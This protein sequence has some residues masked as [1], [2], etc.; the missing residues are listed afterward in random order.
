[1]KPEIDVSL[2]ILADHGRAATFLIHDGIL[3]ANDGRGYVLRKILRRAIRHGRILG[4]ERAFLYQ[5]VG[6]VAELMSDAYPE[7]LETSERVA[8]VVKSEEQRFA[9]TI[10][11]AMHEFDKVA[12]ESGEAGGKGAVILRGD[13][14]FRLY[15]TF[16][17]P[18]DWIKEIAGERGL[19]VD[20]S[21]F[22]TE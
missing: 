4:L 16:G 20:E 22:E 9:Q 17:M 13:K 11:I 21:G 12:K 7:L 3:P 5:M 2:R 15:D 10:T 8:A 1:E 18:L 6:K 14:L 19:E